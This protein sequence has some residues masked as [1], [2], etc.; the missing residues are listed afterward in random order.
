MST[1]SNQPKDARLDL[2]LPHD[3]RALIADAA[4]LAG[5]SL[6]DY[7]LGVVLPAARRDIIETRSIRLSKE[8]WD[9][10]IDILDRPDNPA[11]ASLREH[12]PAW[13]E[14]RT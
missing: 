2:R 9:D 1:V 8:A 13:D 7:V 14:P 10:F 6:T 3:A 4:A 5:M 11:L 12:R